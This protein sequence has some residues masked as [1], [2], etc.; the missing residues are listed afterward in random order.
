[1][2]EIAANSRP[3][4]APLFG[5]LM[6]GSEGGA[7][8]FWVT[9]ASQAGPAQVCGKQFQHTQTVPHVL[10][11][12]TQKRILN[13]VPHLQLYHA[14]ILLRWSETLCKP[15][16]HPNEF[17]NSQHLILQISQYIQ[18]KQIF[19]QQMSTKQEAEQYLGNYMEGL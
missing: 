10:V 18:K 19:Y 17:L 3:S 6:R 1:M 13:F 9:P 7:L 2:V 4:K 5:L 12:C 11:L 16:A 14:K 8:P 15:L